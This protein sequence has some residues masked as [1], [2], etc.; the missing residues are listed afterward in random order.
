MDLTRFLTY[1]ESETSS[2]VTVCCASG[3]GKANGSFSIYAEIW[4]WCALKD[5]SLK[6]HVKERR[7]GQERWGEGGRLI[8][9]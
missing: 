3:R 6:W 5:Q 4:E 2:P 9:S 7:M 1:A 8:G